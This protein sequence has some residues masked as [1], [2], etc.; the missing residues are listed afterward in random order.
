MK[1]IAEVGQLLLRL[2]IGAGFLIPVM[3]RLGLLGPPGSGPSWGD[4][5]H[6]VDYTNTLIPFASRPMANIMGGFSTLAEFV[7]A[8]MLIVGFRI[9]EA[10]LGTALLTL[11]L[12]LCMGIFLK[13]S[14]P[15]D[16]P[17]FVFTGA[18]MVLS[19][20][21]HYKWSIDN[22]VKKRPL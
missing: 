9:K 16:Y 1:R 19:G 21:D 15:F 12:G 18:G 5:K 7:F 6:F 8:I 10:S 13:I 14:A 2:A 17:V 3:D 11:S 20:L 22:Y 4:W